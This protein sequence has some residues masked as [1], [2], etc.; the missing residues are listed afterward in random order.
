MLLPVF[1][2]KIVLKELGYFR[3]YYWRKYATFQLRNHFPTINNF[4][5][6]TLFTP[7][8]VK[9]HSHRKNWR[10]D[11]WKYHKWNAFVWISFNGMTFQVSYMKFHSYYIKNC[12]NGNKN[13]LSF[14]NISMNGVFIVC[15]KIEGL[16][17][18]RMS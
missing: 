15:Y 10:L 9:T 7:F 6:I 1:R 3:S 5:S 2:G 11:G 13:S 14:L 8:I 18:T 12:I 17:H 4:S 16:S